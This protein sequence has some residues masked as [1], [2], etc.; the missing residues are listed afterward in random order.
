L[1][2]DRVKLPKDA[3]TDRVKD[4]AAAVPEEDVGVF[5]AVCLLPEP[6][7]EEEEPWRVRTE[8]E[9]EEEGSNMDL[10]RLTEEVAVRVRFPRPLHSVRSELV[11]C[12]SSLEVE[13]HFLSSLSGLGILEVSPPR[14]RLQGVLRP[15]SDSCREAAS[16]YPVIGSE[17]LGPIFSRLGF[18]AIGGGDVHFKDVGGLGAT[19]RPPGGDEPSRRM[20]GRWNAAGWCCTGVERPEPAKLGGDDESRCRTGMRLAEFGRRRSLSSS[21]SFIVSPN[22]DD[23]TASNEERKIS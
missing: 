16:A 8:P 14:P 6:V 2:M 20:G 1:D 19:S 3:D 15:E 5:V 7:R 11:R 18:G 4:G 23:W 21:L 17:S 13:S 22:G 10:L 12:I 9:E